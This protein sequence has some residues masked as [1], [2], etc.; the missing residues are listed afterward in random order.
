MANSETSIRQACWSNSVSKTEIDRLASVTAGTTSASKA[1]VVGANKELDTLVIAD[2]GLKLGSGA[3]TA[4]TATAA[5]LNAVDQSVVADGLGFLRVARFTFDPSAVAAHRTVGAHGLG[6]TIPDNAIILGGGLEI[7]T[8]FASTDGGT[9]KATIALH[10]QSAN[11]LITA[12]A[13]ETDTFWDAVKYKV[14]VPTAL[15]AGGVATAI[16]LTADREV[17]ATVGTAALTAG[18]FVGWLFYVVGA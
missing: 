13:I 6:V 12:T 1:L 5:E 11:D 9:D 8:G 3:G 2:G 15:E 16:K 7:L 10:V 18:K 17:T 14:V 4:V